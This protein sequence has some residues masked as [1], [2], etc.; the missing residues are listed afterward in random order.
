[1]GIEVETGTTSN[2]DMYKKIIKHHSLAYKQGIY[3][4]I[5][6]ACNN[7]EALEK[8]RDKIDKAIERYYQ[9]EANNFFCAFQVNYYYLNLSELNNKSLRSFLN[10]AINKKLHRW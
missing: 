5:I 8:T 2:S 3:K 10:E 6:I 1:M 4:D 7:K 9:E